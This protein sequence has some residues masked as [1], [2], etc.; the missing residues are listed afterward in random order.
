MAGKVALLLCIAFVFFLLKREKKQMAGVSTALWVPT[1]WLLYGASRPLPYWQGNNLLLAGSGSVTE[2]SSI[3]RNFLLIL[4]VVGC[5]IISKR[6]FDWKAIF[7]ESPWL[8]AVYLYAL[9]SIVWSDVPFVSAKRFIRLAGSLIMGMIILSETSP[10]RA[11]ESV[12]GRMVYILIPFSVLLVKYFP[13]LGLS[14]RQH[15]GERWWTGVTTTKNNLGVLCLLSAFYLIWRLLLRWKEQGTMGKWKLYPEFLVLAMTAYLMKGAEGIY[16]A[17][18]IACLALGLV[19][20]VSL[21][22][23]LQNQN[24]ASLAQT[25]LLVPVLAVALFGAGVP[26]FG[27]AMA[28]GITA[29][30]GRDATFTGRTDIWAELTPM[31]LQAPL[32]GHGYGGFWVGNYYAEVNEAHNGYL[33]TVLEL[34]FAGLMILMGFIV[35]YARQIYRGFRKNIEWA[36]FGSGLL[37]MMVLHNVTEASFLGECDPMWTS[38]IFVLILNGSVMR[39]CARKQP[40]VQPLY[41]A[42]PAEG[43]P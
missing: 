12:L 19:M 5:F 32:L 9:T 11:L 2:G 42:S 14:Y 13:D 34:G 8:A 38:A 36:L 17:T 33:E 40:A 6:R 20:L 26:F 4:I 10:R 3:D 18:S 22:R 35:S 24:R 37:I 23:L 7:K 41:N 25:V 1:L 15:T 29:T 27:T 21:W 30:L 43:R 28:S 31:A 16:S 39:S